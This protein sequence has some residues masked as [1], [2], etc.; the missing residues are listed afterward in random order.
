MGLTRYEFE[1]L[2]CLERK[3]NT[4]YSIRNLSDSLCISSTAV[5]TSLTCQKERGLIV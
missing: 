1:V 4:S 3:E 2:S 5:M